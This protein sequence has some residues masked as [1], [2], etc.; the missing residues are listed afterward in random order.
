MPGQ[1]K[2]DTSELGDSRVRVDVQ[3]ASDAVEHELGTAARTI[4][5][6]LKIPGFRKG[7]VPAEVVMQRVGREAVLDE[8][9]RRALPGWY[10]QAVSDAGIAAVG[11]P[12]LDLTELPDRGS[13]LQFTIEVA[14]RPKAELGEYRGLEVGRREAEAS[15]EEVDA[16]LERLREQAASLENADRPAAKDDFVVVDFTGTIDGEPFEGGEAR[17]LPLELGSGRLVEG[18]EEQLEGASPGDEREVRVT[19]PE[20]YRAEN[21]AGKEAVFA[22]TV[23]EVKE[24]KLPELDDELAEAGG[25][26]TL[27]ELRADIEEKLRAASEREIDGEFREA[28][29]DAAAAEAK[30]DLGHDL[31][32]A[33][34]HEMWSNTRRQLERQGIPA[35]RYLEITGK[36]EEE[37]VQEAEPDAERALRRESVLAA[38]VE[39][40]GIE[41]SDDEVIESLRSAT[42]GS[43]GPEPSD[44]ELAKVLDRARQQGRDD[45]L[46]EDI[47]MR[48]AVD[49]LVENATPISVEQAKA[50][51][52]LWTPEKEGKD[53]SEQLWTPGS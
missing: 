23:K 33:K 51:D 44:K 40:E 9:V 16:E 20:D 48:K 49:L 38:I 30:I 41:I 43:G 31:V 24:K 26:D 53:R 17:G 34:S 36:T 5:R 39:A 42:S 11:D 28:V 22:V 14:V 45:A 46:R 8:A 19:F 1:V 25:F 4:G 50:R 21:L 12:K 2:T 10:E 29:V 27:D 6:D 7:K 13:P 52:K 47:A 37:L 32:H 15:S 18:F 3:V 35:D